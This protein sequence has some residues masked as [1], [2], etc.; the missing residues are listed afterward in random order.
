MELISSYP[1]LFENKGQEGELIIIK[2]PLIIKKQQRIIRNSFREEGKPAN[3][4]DIGVLSEDEWFWVIRDLVLFPNGKYGGYIRMIN[5][6]SNQYGGFN[7]VLICTQNNKILLIK[8]YHHETRDYCFEFPRGFGEPDLSPLDNAKKEVKEEINVRDSPISIL[9]QINEGN[10]G[11]CVAHV[12]VL[13]TE[14]LKVENAEGIVDSFWVDINSLN[15]FVKEGKI[16][17]WFTLWA[18]SVYKIQNY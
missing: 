2:D 7:V 15:Q 6:K 1:H 8:K 5:R 13:S 12:E 16:T 17:D 3:W 14:Q 11:T 10:G 18:L 4:I 9:S